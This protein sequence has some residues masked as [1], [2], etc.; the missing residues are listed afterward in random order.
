MNSKDNLPTD[1]NAYG[2]LVLQPGDLDAD[3]NLAGKYAGSQGYTVPSDFR[4][5]QASGC[6][7]KGGLIPHIG[8]QDYF[9]NST[10]TSKS[11]G[12]DEEEPGVSKV[13]SFR[14]FGR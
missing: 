8:I 11:M 2:G 12:A 10:D 5:S 1:P 3:P 6:R 14:F 7:G 9:G 4:V 13:H